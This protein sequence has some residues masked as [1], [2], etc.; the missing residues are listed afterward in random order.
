MNQELLDKGITKCKIFIGKLIKTKDKLLVIPLDKICKEVILVVA[1]F[2]C[3]KC[4]SE[5]HLQYHHLIGRINRKFINDD[6][7]YI[8]QRHYW[9]NIIILCNDCHDKVHGFKNVTDPLKIR[10]DIN[11][12]F[13]EK[14][15][16]KYK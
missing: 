4:K 12:K 1:G 7:R 11:E 3:Q 8:T 10:R 14:V 5:E 2:K 13:I 15:R 6:I 9:A 16:R